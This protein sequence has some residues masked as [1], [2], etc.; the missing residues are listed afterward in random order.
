MAGTVR[1]ARHHAPGVKEPPPSTHSQ[2]G[3]VASWAAFFVVLVIASQ[4]RTSNAIARGT[5][6]LA[7]LYLSLQRADELTALAARWLSRLE[8]SVNP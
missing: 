4:W 7:L 2:A 3:E 1:P 5:L 6:L 8:S